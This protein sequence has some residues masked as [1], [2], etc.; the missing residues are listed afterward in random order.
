MK[1]IRRGDESPGSETKPAALKGAARKRAE[2]GIEA[3][4]A[5]R[6][7]LAEWSYRPA[8]IAEQVTKRSQYTDKPERKLAEG[9]FSTSEN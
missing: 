6:R 8:K 3:A 4:Q 2:N 5:L 9:Q 7:D 1:L